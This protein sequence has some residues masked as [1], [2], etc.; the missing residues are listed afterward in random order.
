[1]PERNKIGRAAK[2]IFLGLVIALL[3]SG[4]LYYQQQQEILIKEQALLKEQQLIEEQKIAAQKAID[5]ENARLAEEKLKNQKINQVK[6][7]LDSQLSYY[8]DSANL[9]KEK[10][11][12]HA[13][14]SSSSDSLEW[15]LSV[16]RNISSLS[17]VYKPTH[18]FNDFYNN[19]TEGYLQSFIMDAENKFNVGQRDTSK[20]LDGYYQKVS[21]VYL[22]QA[23]DDWFSSSV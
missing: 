16:G 5:V 13:F 14:V 18:W 3:A 20:W 11:E 7:T 19:N 6:S 2:I 23:R 21:N 22:S 12:E 1:M 4:G 9:L 10:L 17:E 15:Q 8:S